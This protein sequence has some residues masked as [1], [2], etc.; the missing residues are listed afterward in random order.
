MKLSLYRRLYKS[1]TPY[2]IVFNN[3]LINSVNAN[4]IHKHITNSLTLKGVY[5]TKVSSDSLLLLELIDHYEFDNVNQL[6][7]LL[8]DRNPEVFI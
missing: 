8:R 6:D 1:N 5:G 3:R 4:S 2:V 7:Q